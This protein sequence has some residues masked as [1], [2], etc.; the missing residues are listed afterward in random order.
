MPIE[1]TPASAD[2]QFLNDRI[3]EF[4]ASTTGIDNGA[5]LTILVRDDPGT[6]VAGLL[7]WTWGDC[8]E[9]KTLWVQA[10]RR[11]QG[12]GSR[13]LAA[14]ETE[15][16]RRGVRQIVLSS[17]TPGSGVLSSA[18]VRNPHRHRGIPVST[19]AALPPEVADLTEFEII[20]VITSAETETRPV[21]RRPNRS[22]PLWQ[23][24]S[25]VVDCGS[26][27]GAALPPVSRGKGSPIP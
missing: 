16:R 9:I 12:L 22:C 14:A 6:I 19:R 27:G 7:G 2:I 15:A 3:Y 1:T 24:S 23:R 18:R 4:N 5:F 11:R 17:H 20:P 8:C 25:D 21:R 26:T 10:D 13:L